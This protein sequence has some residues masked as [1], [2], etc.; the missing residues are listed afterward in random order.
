MNPVPYKNII[1]IKRKKVNNLFKQIPIKVLTCLNKYDITES[2][3]MFKQVSKT[4][5]GNK[6]WENMQ[7]TQNSCCIW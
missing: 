6:R 7:K 5:G 3:N 2:E 1:K 4:G